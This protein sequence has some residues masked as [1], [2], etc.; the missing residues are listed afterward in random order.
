MGQIDHISPKGR[1]II[2]AYDKKLADLAEVP[3]KAKP[4]DMPKQAK[5]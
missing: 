2:A 4:K 5:P 3:A 1:L